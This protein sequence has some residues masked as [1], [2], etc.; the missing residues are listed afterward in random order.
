MTNRSI[1][2]E[3]L[4]A[5]FLSV[6]LAGVAKADGLDRRLFG[7]WVESAA[8]C[9]KVFETRNGRMSFRKPIN[10][11]I[12][13][14]IIGPREIVASGG[15]C[16]VGKVSLKGEEILASLHCNNT[17]GFAPLSARFKIISQ[18]EIIYGATDNPILDSGYEKCR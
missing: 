10:E 6:F 14:F 4:I 7:A 15:R 1:M 12:P 8:D 11:F 17:V 9:Q 3:V 2:A 18:T 16:Q 5:L 13:A